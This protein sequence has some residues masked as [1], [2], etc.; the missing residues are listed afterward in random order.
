MARGGNLPS[1]R[2]GKRD[3]FRDREFRQQKMKLED[4]AEAGEPHFRALVLG[5][6]GGGL[7][8]DQ[9]FA[10]CRK[11]QQ[12]QQVQ[13]RRFAGTGGAGDGDE[14]ARQDGEADVL[15]QRDRHDPAEDLGDAARLDQRRAHVA[16]RMMST[17]CS[18]AAD[19]AGK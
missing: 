15:H 14:F 2:I 19:R 1:A 13:Q 6:D 17:G 11:I 4:E 9:D 12:S 3:I 10:R 8:V 18:R 7:A 16:P 5:H